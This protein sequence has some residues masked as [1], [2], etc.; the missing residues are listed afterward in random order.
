MKNLLILWLLL[1]ISNLLLAQNPGVD[2][3]RWK[4]KTTPPANPEKN[5]MYL[6]A[7]DTLFYMYNGEQ[8]Q[9]HTSKIIPYERTQVEYDAIPIS[10]RKDKLFFILDGGSAPTTQQTN[11][12]YTSSP[13][14]G[15][16]TS[17]TGTNA[18]IPLADATNAGLQVGGFISEGSFEPTI[19]DLGGGA[20]YNTGSSGYYYKIGKLVFFY[21]NLMSIDTTGTPT[22]EL[23]IRNF[24]FDVAV[25]AAINVGT[26]TMTSQ[27]FSGF[28]TINA[29]ILAENNEVKFNI[30]A[31][32]SNSNGVLLSKVMFTNSQLR[33]SGVYITN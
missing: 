18:T 19:I 2:S 31:S 14:N 20:T 13:L 24:P 15:I 22:G 11:L 28:N 26:I 1:S 12:A 16:I 7:T 17:S 4:A 5:Q 6:N 21:M 9:Q 32:I 3:E 23:S 33:L 10:E 30:S 27:Y 8:W 29:S 25:N